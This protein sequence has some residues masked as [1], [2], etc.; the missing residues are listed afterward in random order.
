MPSILDSPSPAQPPTPK[1]CE[2]GCGQ[3]VALA[4]K[5]LT[6]RGHIKGQPV[7]FIPGHHFK[8]STAPVA[9]GD[10]SLQIPLTRGAASLLSLEDADLATLHWHVSHEGYANRMEWVIPRKTCRA[11]RLHRV[12]LERMLGR[13]LQPDEAVDHINGDKL[14]NR[15]ENLRLATW[16]QNSQNKPIQ[17]NN[18]SGYRGVRHVPGRKAHWRAVIT[19]KGKS[20]H[21]G[22]FD[23]AE[24]AA[25]AY[26]QAATELFGEW[27]YQKR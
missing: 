9:Y 18:T 25:A 1:L 14:D 26:E 23:T 4:R 5:T 27:K 17:A 11:F 7:R 8:R 19:V 22:Y 10:N 6:K 15:R 24:A 13:S 21:L 3:P 12:V 20:V 16:Q 2:C